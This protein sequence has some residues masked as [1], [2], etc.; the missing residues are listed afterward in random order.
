MSVFRFLVG[1]S[2]LLRCEMVKAFGSDTLWKQPAEALAVAL[3]PNDMDDVCLMAHLFCRSALHD[4]VSVAAQPCVR[5]K[6][7]TGLV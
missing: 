7:L 2:L 5:A 3:S 1:Q 6:V 4:T